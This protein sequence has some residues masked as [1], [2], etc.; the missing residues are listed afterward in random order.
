MS[1]VPIPLPV[2]FY[3]REVLLVAREL[4]GCVLVHD[5]PEGPA[6]GV[7]VETEAYHESDPAC[8]AYRGKTARNAPLFGPPGRSYVYFTY[9]MHWCANAVTGPE[10]E[11]AAVLIRAL[12]PLEGIAGMQARR[13]LEGLRDL[14]RGPARLAQ[15]LGLASEQ[16]DLSLQ[17][18]PLRV[19]PRPLDRSEPK[20]ETS[21]R[22][23]ISVGQELEWRFTAAG[24]RFL[25]RP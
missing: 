13:K 17:A 22:I 5:A 11:A 19:Y 4:I 10:G 23:G 14:C 15:A 12:E 20:I 24:S 6:S 9:G 1:P 3:D 7:I 21:A 8:H 16:N 2:A 18:S 25:S